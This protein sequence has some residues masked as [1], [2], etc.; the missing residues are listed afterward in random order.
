MI[1]TR[2]YLLHL[3]RLEL[4]AREVVIEH[5]VGGDH[6]FIVEPQLILMIFGIVAESRHISG[7]GELDPPGGQRR[8]IGATVDLIDA[9]LARSSEERRVGKEC[10]ST[11]RSRGAPY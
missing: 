3:Q 5:G 9:L 7:L 6:R 11:G 1:I 4:G 2:W 10:V 8:V